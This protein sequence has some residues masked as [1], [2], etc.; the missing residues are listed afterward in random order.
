MVKTGLESSFA[1]RRFWGILGA[2]LGVLLSRGFWA[3]GIE[4][5]GVESGG[6]PEVLVVRGDED[7][8]VGVFEVSFGFP[9]V[10]ELLESAGGVDVVVEVED[11]FLPVLVDLYGQEDV[12]CEGDVLGGMID[13]AGFAEEAG[14]RVPPCSCA[15]YGDAGLCGNAEGEVMV[16]VGD[17]DQAGAGVLVFLVGFVEGVGDLLVGPAVVGS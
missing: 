14:G 3:D 15:V 2:F 8:P 10:L 13:P 1:L 11:D 6:G 17:D 12:L 7:G 5:E 4:G 9:E 16:V